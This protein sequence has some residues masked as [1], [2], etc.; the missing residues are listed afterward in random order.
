MATLGRVNRNL[1]NSGLNRQ[2]DKTYFQLKR[3]PMAE[4]VMGPNGE[5]A[6]AV[7]LIVHGVSITLPPK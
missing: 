6:T 1:K 2:T 5:A 3:M 4:K 7:L